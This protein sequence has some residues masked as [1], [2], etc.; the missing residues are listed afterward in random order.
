MIDKILRELDIKHPVERFVLSN[1]TFL[2]GKTLFY[3]N[4]PSAL[5][6]LKH[7]EVTG[8]SIAD[9]GFLVKGTMVDLSRNAV[10]KVAYFKQ[11]LLK[12]ALLGFNVVWLY[13]EDVYELENYPK[14]GYLRGRYSLKE[15]NELDDYAINL[16]IE[17]VPC[18]QTLGHMG[19]FLR[20]PS[21]ET[22]KDQSDVLMI[23]ESIP[24]IESMIRFCKEAFKS[25]QIHIGMDET[26]GFSFG[27][28]YKKYGYTNP[29]E[30]FLQH[31]NTV[32]GLCLKAGYQS[33]L[34]WSDMFFR[35]RSKVNYYYDTT[36]QFE[37][38]FIN[39]IPTNVGLV[40]WDYYN[41]S[42]EIYEKMLE[43]HQRTN[44]RVIMASGVW[45]WTKL[46]YD[47][48]QTKKTAK[49]A[50]EAAK[51]TGIQ[52]IIFTQWQD[53]GAYVDYE[54]SY[55]GLFDVTQW[56][57]GNQVDEHYLMYLTNN[58]YQNYQIISQINQ[59]GYYP[60]RLLWDDLLLGIYLNNEIG[61]DEKKLIPWINRT[62]K[63]IQKL[64]EID[65]THHKLIVEVLHLK[66]EIRASFLKGYFTTYDLSHTMVLLKRFK[67]SIKSLSLSFDAMWHER[68][69]PFGLE[70]L[71]SRLYAQIKRADEAMYWI[72]AY[73]NKEV[74]SIPFFDET[75]TK[76]P[77]IGVKHS[78]LAYSSKQ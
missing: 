31:L 54:T 32:N 51:K 66:L 18:I 61:Y 70:V 69:K 21:S 59:V 56:A 33:V 55:Q 45:I 14:F 4:I 37:E 39:K 1:K 71:Q 68:Y 28:H 74:D 30:L 67:V 10:F 64:K 47:H 50:I 72:S 57:C 26:F 8:K 5:L 58:S 44:R 48:E 46:A 63:H 20:W 12:K 23:H 62:K 49:L 17:L 29:E 11:V 3:K 36:I 40:Y 60:V 77:Y 25:N 43:I 73:T 38:D 65:Q 7:L 19:Q 27:Q 42:V 16:G 76:E 34:M 9:D 13:M 78:D 15:L 35:H 53:D 22:F 24:L 6:F 75:I 41:L 2:E 52:E